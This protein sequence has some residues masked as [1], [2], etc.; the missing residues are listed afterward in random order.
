M[1]T[2]L[3]LTSRNLRILLQKA[4]GEGGIDTAPAAKAGLGRRDFMRNLSVL[5]IG[6]TASVH[7]L[8]QQV[9]KSQWT[10][11]FEA[12]YNNADKEVA[13]VQRR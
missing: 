11:L 13:K 8:A 12:N 3:S 1:K 2:L 7:A 6:T 10:A 4:P 5:I 9:D